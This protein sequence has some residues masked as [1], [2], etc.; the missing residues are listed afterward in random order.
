M[1]SVGFVLYPQT[2]LS[3][4]TLPLEMLSAADQFHRTRQRKSTQ[5]RVLIA[6]S[7]EAPCTRT[8]EQTPVLQTNCD[9]ADLDS[10]DLLYLPA[11]WRNPLPVL[12]QSHRV[13]PLLRRLANDSRLIC[14]VG[15][16]SCF[17]AEAGLLDHRPATTHWFF[18]QQFAHRYPAVQT[19]TRHLITRAGNLYCASSINGVADLTGHFIERFYGPKIARQVDAHF[20]PEIRRSFH[21]H[22]FIE[23]ESNQHHD[24]L[25][26]DA[27]QWLQEHFAD[28]VNMAT[29]ARQLD[30]S[31]R[32]L[33][34]RFAQACGLTPVR[35]LQQLRIHHA[36]EL[37]RDT[38]LSVSDIAVEVGY[39]D[40]G[41]F[42][43][44]FRERMAQTATGYRRSVRGKL[45]TPG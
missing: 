14:S 15:T 25:M 5:L 23:G 43:T 6:N 7:Q 35:Y 17:L 8:T 21:E 38:N 16:G 20:S 27:Q 39:Q 37:L 34:R 12:R 40:L 45:F 4:V 26:I 1:L 44:L 31:Q 3:S 22:G 32:S 19:K 41:Y 2:L 9:F 33:N 11:I 36:C 42:S 28:G 29:L 30:I 24:E 13:M 18:L 10:V